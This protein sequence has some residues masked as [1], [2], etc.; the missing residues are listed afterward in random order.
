M[1]ISTTHQKRYGKTLA[2]M[3][4]HL[5]QRS[6]L[7][8]LGTENPFTPLLKEAGYTVQN[9]QGENLDDDY[10]AY[11]DTSVDCVTAF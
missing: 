3:E 10:M 6:S 9:T 7:L 1:R 4:K 5:E 8:D 2:F 11:A